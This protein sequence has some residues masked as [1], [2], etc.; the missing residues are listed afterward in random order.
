LDMQ[1]I[2][3]SKLSCQFCYDTL[4]KM[5]GGYKVCGT[6]GEMARNWKLTDYF[7]QKD[8]VDWIYSN[9]IPHALEH[10]R[11]A[12]TILHHPLRQ[13]ADLSPH[14]EEKIDDDVVGAGLMEIRILGGLDQIKFDESVE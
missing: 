13:Q 1:Y 12:K 5:N 6:H 2:G 9:V 7:A 14:D 4:L 10:V 3:I 8:G 11:K